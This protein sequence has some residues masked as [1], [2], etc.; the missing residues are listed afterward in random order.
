MNPDTLEMSRETMHQAW[1]DLKKDKDVGIPQME[2]GIFT[3]TPISDD[4]HIW[5][6]YF[7]DFFE[8]D[9]FFTSHFCRWVVQCCHIYGVGAPTGIDNG[10]A[11]GRMLTSSPDLEKLSRYG[12]K[13]RFRPS[14]Y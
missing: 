12:N 8:G 2:R 5:V 11:V 6:E 10:R 4:I 7:L 14:M 1:E 3:V 9:W 13:T